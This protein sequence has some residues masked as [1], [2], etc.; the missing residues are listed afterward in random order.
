M[1]VLCLC[2]MSAVIPAVIMRGLLIIFLLIS[3]TIAAPSSSQTESGGTSLEQ[4]QHQVQQ[5]FWWDLLWLQLP[6]VKM[7]GLI[8]HYVPC[9]TTRRTATGQTTTSVSCLEPKGCFLLSIW[10]REV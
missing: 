10:R 9:C 3:V 2:V 6:T 5:D 4:W 8:E 1:G 7:L